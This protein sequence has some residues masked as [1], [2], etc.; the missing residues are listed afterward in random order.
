MIEQYEIL[1]KIRETSSN[2][3]KQEILESH[4]NDL[5]LKDI[6]EFVYNPYFRTGLSSKKINKIIPQV[7]YRLLLNESGSISYI[8]KY[9][10]DNNTGTDKDIA[11]VQWYIRNYSEGESEIVKEILTQNLK[12]GMTAKSINKVW[13]NLIPEFDVMLAEKY[14]EKVDK[15]EIDTPEIIITQKL[16]VM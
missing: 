6:L 10:R 16:E 11:Q 14:W 2:N 9:L 15:L 13:N 3:E 7:E 12:I 4:K 8:F 1:K 5:L